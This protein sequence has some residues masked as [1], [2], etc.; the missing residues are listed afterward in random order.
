LR[1]IQNTSQYEQF[2]AKKKEVENDLNKWA[3]PHAASRK[4]FH[5]TSEDVTE[6]ICREGFNR[7]FAGKNAT[8][9]GKGMYFAVSPKYPHEKNFASPNKAGVRNMFMVE[10]ATGEYAPTRGT[11]DMLVP[12]LRQSGGNKEF[13]HSVVD[14]PSSPEIFV[15]FKDACAYPLYWLT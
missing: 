13:Y 3:L 8:V 11:S 1:R 7:S 4:L 15:V 6:H 5:G 14:N 10:V 9:Y 2:Y 12:P